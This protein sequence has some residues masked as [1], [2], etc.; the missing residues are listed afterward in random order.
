MATLANQT[1]GGEGRT[2][3]I[4]LENQCYMVSQYVAQSPKSVR[5]CSPPRYLDA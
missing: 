5:E 3:N 4:Y 1:K 2:D